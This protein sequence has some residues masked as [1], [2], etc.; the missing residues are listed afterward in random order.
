MLKSKNKNKIKNSYYKY[1]TL[2]ILSF[3][4]YFMTGCTIPFLSSKPSDITIVYESLWEK[5]G[6]YE[7]VFANYK[8]D[9]TYVSI[10]FQDRTATDITAYKADLLDRLKNKRNVPDVIRIHV[11]WLPEFKDYL[12]PAPA[13][14]FT[15]ETI[16]SNYYPSVSSL[17][18]YKNADNSNYF[19]YGV[20]LY[21]D[22]LN[23]V[24][25]T[26]HFN[27]AG[28]KA[29]PA[30]WE[31]FF[32]NAYFLTKK[33]ASNQVI[34]S[35]A[36]FGNKDLE[37]YTDIFGLLLGNANLEFPDSLNSES[38][39]LESVVRVLNRQTDWNPAFQNSGNAFVSRRVSMAILPTW[40]VNDILSAN[41]DI[42]L[43]VAPVPSSRQDRPMNWPTFFVEA[44]PTSAKDTNESWKLIKYMSSEESAKNIYSKQV[45]VRRLPS[46]PALKN[47][48]AVLDIDPI[49]KSVALDAANSTPGTGS[50]Y[51][52]VMSDRSGNTP[53]VEGIKTI[54]GQNS[55]KILT[56]SSEIIVQAC[57]LNSAK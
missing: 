45:S 50:M 22:Q 56:E 54:L 39:S 4:L 20:P 37:F 23:L 34:R 6:T 28:Y 3:C 26:S 33:D 27:E 41:K 16:D 51:S 55:A 31:Q 15:K 7:D 36:A 10:D 1:L 12:T 53:C 18:V 43:A 14:Y 5:S 46:L 49:L 17:V 8:K 13:D 32:R 52:F 29:A 40:R 42:E 48:A 57:S 11:S 47:L 38:D 44:V 9:N 35:G 21:Y 19:I 2:S 24:Y 25:N 30:T